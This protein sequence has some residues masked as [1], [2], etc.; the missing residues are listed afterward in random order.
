MSVGDMFFLCV[1]YWSGGAGLVD[2][3]W[4]VWW[5]EQ[6]RR[7]KIDGRERKKIEQRDR[8]KKKARK[9]QNNIYTAPNYIHVSSKIP[10]IVFVIPSL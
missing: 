8:T 2:D 5:C 10:S 6:W 7:E 9:Q 1:A 3:A 4:V